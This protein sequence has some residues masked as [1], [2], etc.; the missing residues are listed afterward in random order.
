[1][2]MQFCCFSFTYF[3]YCIDTMYYSY[4]LLLISYCSASVNVDCI[5]DPHFFIIRWRMGETVSGCVESVHYGWVV[6][7]NKKDGGWTQGA[8]KVIH[9]KKDRQQERET[10]RE[11]WS[12]K[13][14]F[15][16]NIWRE[17]LVSLRWATQRLRTQKRCRKQLFIWIFLFFFIE[18]FNAVHKRLW[19]FYEE[20]M[21]FCIKPICTRFVFH[22]GK[23]KY[24]FIILKCFSFFV[25][26]KTKCFLHR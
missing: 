20:L 22:N 19:L 26:T 14:T 18:H 25:N 16:K 15:R 7:S 9:G 17:V 24:I 6:G 4:Y 23:I 8:Q 3:G 13:G 5:L 2:L 1:M 12:M 21:D 11:T 10:G